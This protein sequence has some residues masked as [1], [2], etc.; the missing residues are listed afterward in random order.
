MRIVTG[1]DETAAV[2]L[3]LTPGEAAELRD[4]LLAWDGLPHPEAEWHVHISDTD[5][6]LTL[7]IGSDARNLGQPS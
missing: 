4:A 1:G 7:T 6:L 2:W 5:R 3:D